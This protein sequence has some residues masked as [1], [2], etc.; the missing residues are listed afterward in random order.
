M[1]EDIPVGVYDVIAD[2]GQARGA[3][4]ATILPNDAL[5]VAALRPDDPAAREHPAAPRPLRGQ[6]TRPG[7]PRSRR[8]TRATAPRARFYRT[9]WHEIGHYLGPDRDR[10]GRDLD[11]ALKDAADSLEEMKADLVSLF[12]A[13]GP[14]RRGATTTTPRLRG[15]YA[16]GI[17]RVLR[18]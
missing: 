13:P 12:V 2:F 3:N 6:P 15:L 11:D 14:A 16:A 8:R 7:R 18:T 1:R 9:L 10:E 17:R 4:T 5:L